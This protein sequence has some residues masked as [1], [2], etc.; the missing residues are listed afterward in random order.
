LLEDDFKCICLEFDP[1][2]MNEI[3]PLPFGTY[4]LIGAQ[5]KLL[6][7]A[8][9][10]RPSWLGRRL[11][12]LVRKLVLRSRSKPI[13]AIADGFRI[14]A[15]VTD[16][17]SERKFLFMPQF[18]DRS[19]R[20]YL[21]ANLTPDGVFLDVGAN[22]GIYTL[23]AARRFSELG[24]NG[25]VL[26]VEANPTMQARLSYNVALNKLEKHVHMAPFALSDR[27]GEV[28]FSIS[29]QNLGESGLLATGSKTIQIPAVTL[30]SLLDTHGIKTLDGMKIDVEGAEDIILV[31]FLRGATR[32][33]LPAFIIIEN[34]ADRWHTDLLGL[35]SEVGYEVH[36]PC[37]M[38]LILRLMRSDHQ[39]K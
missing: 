15:H 25:Y 30:A 28:A 33:Q 19:E 32:A 38:N 7:F 18:C 13:D 20:D 1:L 36:M 31:P 37:K 23:T 8:Q 4:R 16:N 9:Q 17:I 10:Q 26:A 2:A 11:A 14:R 34:S 21:S 12:L 39:N 24:G 29:D 35:L 27:N 5:E 22:A 6:A 3:S